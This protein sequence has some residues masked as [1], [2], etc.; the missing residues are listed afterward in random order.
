MEIDFWKQRWQ[1]NQI[2]FHL[3]EVNP[4][5]VKFI[6][7][8]GLQPGAHVFVP[9]CGKSLDVLWLKNAGYSVTGIECSELAIQAFFNEHQLPVSHR[10]DPV[11]ASY[12][13]DEIH[14][15][16]GDYFDLTPDLLADVVAVYDRA[17]LIALPA[18]MRQR[19]VR[20]LFELLPASS[21]MLLVTL[22]YNQAA[23]AG[24]PFS[25][26]E[27]EVRKLYSAR[28]SIQVL[29]QTSV[30]DEQP[31]FAQRGLDGLLETV[32]LLTP[33]PLPPA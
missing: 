14:L 12:K 24:P 31:R 4:A 8:L 13:A 26:P 6:P 21:Q 5:L 32:Y 15:L 19:Y 25:V 1:E 11:I 27:S 17:A 9:M 28:F 20:K 7:A 18:E 29:Q 30:L 33:K 10:P 2:G 3:N 22:E 16:H 23:M